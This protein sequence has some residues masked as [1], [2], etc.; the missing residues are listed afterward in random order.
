M[1]TPSTIYW[2]TRLD[3]FKDM[4]NVCGF[5]F[6]AVLIVCL[7]H[8]VASDISLTKKQEKL[9]GKIALISFVFLFLF[10]A[11]N[12]FTPSTKEAAAMYAI[13]KIANN[14]SVQQIPPALIKILDKWGDKE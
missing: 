8:L 12:I 6:F 5:I 9:V 10:V 14:E 2:I 7:I 13:P 3:Y 11:A 4:A 1:I